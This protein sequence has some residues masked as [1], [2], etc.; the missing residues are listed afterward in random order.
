MMTSM[1]SSI[2]PGL[3]APGEPRSGVQVLAVRWLAQDNARC[4]EHLSRVFLFSGTV[5]GSPFQLSPALLLPPPMLENTDEYPQVHTCA[6]T[7][8]QTCTHARGH[9]HTCALTLLLFLPAVVSE[10]GDIIIFHI[11]FHG[12]EAGARVFFGK[13]VCH[14]VRDAQVV[15]DSLVDMAH[16]PDQKHSRHKVGSWKGDGLVAGDTTQATGT[17]GSPR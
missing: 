13:G 15:S 10:V 11:P 4:W 1:K 8:T 5:P 12:F 3:T 16:R 17:A 7:H 9:A 14:I 6:H 2:G